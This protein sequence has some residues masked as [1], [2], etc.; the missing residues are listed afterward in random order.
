MYAEYIL[1]SRCEVV[2]E[3]IATLYRDGYINIKQANEMVRQHAPEHF[4]R[5][6]WLGMLAK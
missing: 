3:K 4:G 1:P 5:I 6:S 2:L